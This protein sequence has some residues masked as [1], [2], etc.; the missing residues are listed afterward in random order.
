MNDLFGPKHTKGEKAFRLVCFSA[1]ALPLAI[2]VVLL[3]SVTHQATHSPVDMK[4]K[5]AR[6]TMGGTA[7][8]KQVDTVAAEKPTENK[9]TLKFLTS[10]SS[11]KAEK[12][13]IRAGLLGTIYLMLLTALIALPLGIA[14][15]VFL[16]EYAGKTRFFRFVE[17]NIANLAGV[18]SVVYG[19]LGAGIFLMFWRSMSGKLLAGAFTLAILILPV[20][21]I[22]VR[23]ALRSIPQHYRHAALGLGATKWQSIRRVVLPMAIPGIM[24]GAI[25]SLSRAIGETAPLIIVGA[26]LSIRFSPTPWPPSELASSDFTALPMQ[27]FHWSTHHKAAFQGNAAAGIVV[28]LIVLLSMNSVAIFLRNRKSMRYT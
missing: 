11:Y 21:I 22:T 19:I 26:A 25:L 1:C 23:E 14:A 10:H 24:T 8:Q 9:L 17:I 15:A 13:G 5:R 27:I 12:S 3:V 7:D 6:V 2:L 4:K 20:I 28:L 16:E 18:P